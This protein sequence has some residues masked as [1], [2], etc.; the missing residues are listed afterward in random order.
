MDAQRAG[1]CFRI[2]HAQCTVL[3][4]VPSPPSTQHRQITASTSSPLIVIRPP[5]KCP[6]HA[7]QPR[8]AAA[9][10]SN[11]SMSSPLMFSPDRTRPSCLPQRSASTEAPPAP[12]P[13]TEAHIMTNRFD[14]PTGAAYPPHDAVDD[15]SPTSTDIDDLIARLRAAHD[16]GTTIDELRTRLEPVLTCAT[17]AQ[18]ALSL[19]SCEKPSVPLGPPPSNPTAEEI[20]QDQRRSS[21]PGSSL[22]KLPANRSSRPAETSDQAGLPPGGASRDS[23]IFGKPTLPAEASRACST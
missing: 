11:T 5:W 16:A 10:I 2:I 17:T 14:T 3:D 13:I 19:S 9:S 4:I 18:A 22:W 20:R 23:H 6:P 12:T 8:A 21:E 15:A 1:T 7:S